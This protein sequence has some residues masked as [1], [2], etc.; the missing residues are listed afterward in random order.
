MFIGLIVFLLC[1]MAYFL[2]AIIASMRGHHQTMAI[3]FL[4]LL[5]GWTFLGW[6]VAFVWACTAVRPAAPLTIDHAEAAGATR[7]CPSCAERILMAA[8]VCKHCGRAVSGG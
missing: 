1:G 8:K 3:F 7:A 6:L 4:T 2:P 5:G